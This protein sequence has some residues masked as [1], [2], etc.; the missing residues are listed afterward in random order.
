MWII[1]FYVSQTLLAIAFYNLAYLPTMR[2]DFF[3]WGNSNTDGLYLLVVPFVLLPTI[4]VT[5]MI[6]YLVTKKLD[7]ENIYKWTFVISIFTSVTC[8]LL[9]FADALW[10]TVVIALL[11]VI[12][13][14]IETIILSRQFLTK[15]HDVK[16]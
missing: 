16:T 7:I 4:L 10:P 13:I 6:K 14:V 11:T 12:A 5:S 1:L 8:T 9:V 3:K 2:I 15:G